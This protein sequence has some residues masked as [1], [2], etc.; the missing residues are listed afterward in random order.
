MNKLLLIVIGVLAAAA[1]VTSYLYMDVS[2][3]LSKVENSTKPGPTIIPGRRD[4]IYIRRETGNMAQTVKTEYV[5][6]EGEKEIY[7]G[8]YDSVMVDSSMGITIRAE[9]GLPEKTFLIEPYVWYQ[10]PE[11]F[12]SDT[13]YVPQV[14]L[15][16]V[17]V[18]WYE[19]PYLWGA[20]GVVAGV[21]I[22]SR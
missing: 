3:K 1:A 16:D 19:N 7:R 17:E 10:C 2:R 14:V 6:L 18:A 9:F 5:Y 15:R 8:V 13:V 12:W 4:T 21:L 20:A 22:G 11:V